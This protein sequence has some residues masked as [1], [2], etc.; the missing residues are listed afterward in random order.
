[1]IITGD[2]DLDAL[3]R[4]ELILGWHAEA[5]MAKA[6]QA[7]IAQANDRIS[8]AA[9]EGIGQRIMSMDLFAFTDWE[10]REPG[11]TSDPEWRRT[12]MRDNPE[13]RVKYTPAKTTV[14][15]PAS[16]EPGARSRE[17]NRMATAGMGEVSGVCPK[18][19]DSVLPGAV[20]Q[21]RLSGESGSV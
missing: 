1:M 16:W 5:A 11:I 20:S 14:T 13:L 21:T 10:R 4:Q 2:E 12:M 7:R 8:N 17:S 15:V 9:I 3:V 6:R 18:A 19:S